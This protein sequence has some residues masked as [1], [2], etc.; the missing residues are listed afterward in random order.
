MSDL[1]KIPDGAV[2]D[3]G[4]PDAVAKRR[5]LTIQAARLG[6]VACVLLAVLAVNHAI[7]VPPAI[8]YVLLAIGILGFAVIPVRL[9]RQWK[10][11]RR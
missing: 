6:G 9:A 11:K 5:F 3:D 2:P 1:G 7:P 10:S 8:G 4:V